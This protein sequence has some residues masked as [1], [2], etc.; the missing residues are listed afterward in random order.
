MFQE[1][2]CSPIVFLEDAENNGGGFS[3]S[4]KSI[5]LGKRDSISACG[6]GTESKRFKLSEQ[7]VHQQ[8]VPLS[9]CLFS[10]LWFVNLML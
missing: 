4:E 2:S 3:A 7:D 9:T 6:I 1:M 5:L 8:E 10:C